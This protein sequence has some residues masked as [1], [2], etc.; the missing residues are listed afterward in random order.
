MEKEI[1]KGSDAR[2]AGIDEDSHNNQA[3][4]VEIMEK[5]DIFF[6]YRPKAKIADGGSGANVKSIKDI[7]RFFMVTAAAASSNSS[8]YKLQQQGGQ[9]SSTNNTTEIREE[10]KE[11]PKYRLFVIGKKSL[12]EIRTSEARR[13][14]RYWAKVGGIFKNPEQLTS[15]LLADEFRSGDAA[16]PVGEGKYAIVKHQD[17][18]EL[19]YVLEMPEEPGEAQRELGIEKEASYIISV[20]NPKVPVP[21]GYPSSEEPPHYPESVLNEFGENENFVSLARDLRFIDFQNAQIIL[22]GSKE[23]RDVIQKE[24]GIDIEE[25][26]ETLHSA[27]VFR[28]LK[29]EKGRLPTKALIEGKFE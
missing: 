11:S 6:F 1:G 2:R 13:S 15:E 18:A 8:N 3:S 26:K 16:R 5:G 19:V 10:E 4:A 17:H 7:R 14:E 22:I 28:R 20:I 9:Y 23:G 27:D 12:P 24:F 21:Q 25:E 29:I